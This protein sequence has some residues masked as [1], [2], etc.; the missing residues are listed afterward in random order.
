MRFSEARLLL[1]ELSALALLRGALLTTVR[2]C[3]MVG[4]AW[5]GL[6]TGARV[7]AG[8]GVTL[9]AFFCRGIRCSWGA[10]SDEV[11]NVS[12]RKWVPFWSKFQI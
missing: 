11:R 1:G 12:R 9:R 7:R 2:R 4:V 6:M 5:A 8:G 10:I 3:R